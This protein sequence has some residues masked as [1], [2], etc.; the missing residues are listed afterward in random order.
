MIATRP[1]TEALNLSPGTTYTQLMSWNDF[2]RVVDARGDR[3]LPRLKYF[4][5]IL[6]AAMP[7][8]EHS[9]L[10]SLLYDFIVALLRQQRQQGKRGLYRKG[11]AKD[12]KREEPRVWV[13]ADHWFWLENVQ[14]GSEI[15]P[16]I[17]TEVDVTSPTDPNT[18]A[19]L[20]VPE[21]WIVRKRQLR[22]Y[23]F[24]DDAYQPVAL[25]QFFPDMDVIAK[26]NLAAQMFLQTSDA[27]AAIAQ[28]LAD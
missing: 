6:Y 8:T 10:D 28:A 4:D 16:D 7:E 18:Y 23:S 19:P 9:E 20:A 24:V 22:L 2:L 25:S 14:T 27:D 13:Q 11:S 21:V 17:V 3:A 26:F 12:L 1:Q 15:Q 5:G